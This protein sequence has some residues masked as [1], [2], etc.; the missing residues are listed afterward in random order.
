MSEQ[1]T[2]HQLSTSS[3]TPTG[4]DAQG[5]GSQHRDLSSS[6]W[7]QQ[8]TF[9]AAHKQ[10]LHSAVLRRNHLL[11][12]Q[13]Q[14]SSSALGTSGMKHSTP[15]RSTSGCTETL[16]ARRAW[17]QGSDPPTK[18][19]TSSSNALSSNTLCNIVPQRMTS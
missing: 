4:R 15:R 3:F 6:S 17:Q 14:Q 8:F 11:P 18:Q 7:D 1:W 12:A 2:Q 9:A 10:Q 16:Q 19:S 13:E 5:P